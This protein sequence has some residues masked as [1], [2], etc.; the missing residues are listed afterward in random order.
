[1]AA[2]AAAVA[3]LQ[4]HHQWQQRSSSS[5][6]QPNTGARADMVALSDLQ[7][8]LAA[9][10][11][12]FHPSRRNILVETGYVTLVGSSQ[13]KT[14]RGGEAGREE[15]ALVGLGFKVVT[16]IFSHRSEHNQ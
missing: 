3:A 12:V 2:Q 15:H 9:L 13:P 14:A 8:G 5:G 1:M 10:F 11:V 6:S 16:N 7:G 4:E